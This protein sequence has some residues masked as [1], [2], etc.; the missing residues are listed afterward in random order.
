MAEERI[1]GH[2]KRRYPRLKARVLYKPAKLIGQK[3]QV[4]DISLG[5]M[6]IYSN[7]YYSVGDALNIELS[8][9]SGQTATAVTRVAWVEAYPKDS[10]AAY[11]LG[12]E[13]IHLPFNAAHELE[14]VLKNSSSSE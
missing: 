6:R 4:P 13:F 2:N 10:D 3:R 8:L 14:S 9:P 12:L 11:D 1:A 5:G 7:K